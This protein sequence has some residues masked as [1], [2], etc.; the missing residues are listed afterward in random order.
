MALPLVLKA[1]YKGLSRPL[2]L[3]VVDGQDFIRIGLEPA[4]SLLLWDTLSE[5]EREAYA[6]LPWGAVMT[7]NFEHLEL[8]HPIVRHPSPTAGVSAGD[9]LEITPS[10]SMLRVLYRRGDRGNVLFATER[11][12]SF[13]LMCSQPP[14]DSDD[15]WRVQH[16]TNLIQLIDRD[17]RSLA[18]TGGEP[19]LLGDGLIQIVR[20]CAERLPNTDLQILSNGRLLADGLLAKAAADVAHPLLQWDVPLYADVGPIHDY[21]VQAKG[22][23]AQTIEGLYRLAEHGHRIEIRV[24]LHKPTVARLRQLCEFIYRNLSFVRH[25][26]LMGIEPIGFARANRDALWIDPVD[27]AG[28]VL[29]AVRFLTDRGMQTSIYNLP[30]CVLPRE[31]WPFAAQS[32]SDWKSVYLEKCQSCALKGRCAGFFA[33]TDKQWV[34]RGVKAVLVRGDYEIQSAKSA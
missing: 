1:E 28:D 6:A 4:R 29:K 10:R 31:V 3:K 27:F 20:A 15:A 30:L 13:C 32:I 16:L 19:A 7:S 9:V 8:P 21:V 2:V 12:N 22:A 18:I 11:C 33:S 23:F 5:P 34:S 14:K 24:V 25:V 26:A 17:E